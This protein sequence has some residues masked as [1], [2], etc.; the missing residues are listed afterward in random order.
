M[1]LLGIDPGSRV[2]G[3]GLLEV[4]GKHSRYLASGCLRLQAEAMPQR[5]GEIFQGMSAIIKEHQPEAMAIERVFLHRN[6]DSALKLGQARG[7][8][9]VAAVHAGLLVYEYSPNEIKQAIVGRG[10]ADKAQIQHMIKVLLNL[11]ATPPADAADALALALCHAHHQQYHQAVN[12]PVL[13][14]SHPRGRGGWRHY[15]PE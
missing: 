14:V 5:L 7:A 9:L 3:F 2:T 1:R 10:H 13:P 8:A 11:S 12:L 6:A 15:K 4:E